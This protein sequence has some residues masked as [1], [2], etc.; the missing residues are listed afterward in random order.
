[1]SCFR[2]DGFPQPTWTKK[3]C[4]KEWTFADLAPFKSGTIFFLLFSEKITHS[5]QENNTRK[6]KTFLSFFFLD[7][8]FSAS[9]S[10]SSIMHQLCFVWICCCC[11]FFWMSFLFSVQEQR[12]NWLA[13][14]QRLCALQRLY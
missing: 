12:K 9:V 3:E 11:F 5:R 14:C 8:H 13:V 7:T 2:L 6:N 10:V 4:S 1:M